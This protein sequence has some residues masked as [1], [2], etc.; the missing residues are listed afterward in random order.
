MDLLGGCTL[1]IGSIF[2]EFVDLSTIRVWSLALILLNSVPKQ[3]C[4]RDTLLSRAVCTCVVR[5]NAE[6]EETQRAK[7]QKR[8]RHQPL[9]QSEK[10]NAKETCQ[11]VRGEMG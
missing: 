9:A 8:L 4:V 1:S 2:V 11:A 10:S 6:P 3:P 5:C 7:P